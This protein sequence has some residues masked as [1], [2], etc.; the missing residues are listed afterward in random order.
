L[1]DAGMTEL[2][3]RTENLTRDFDTVRQERCGGR[4]PPPPATLIQ[5]STPLNPIGR[6]AKSKTSLSAWVLRALEERAY[7]SA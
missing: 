1:E 3:I 2:A 6:P 4:S 7:H 5:R